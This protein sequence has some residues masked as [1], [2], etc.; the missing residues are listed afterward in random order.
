MFYYLLDRIL[1]NDTSYWKHWEGLH[2]HWE[3]SILIDIHK[4]NKVP[5]EYDVQQEEH[6]RLLKRTGP[7][8]FIKCF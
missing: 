5:D 2:D 3:I 4:G 6:D 7:D 1:S 8:P